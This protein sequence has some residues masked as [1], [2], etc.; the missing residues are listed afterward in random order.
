M[1]RGF[2]LPEIAVVTALAG[3]MLALA[4]PR[5][6]RAL[7]HYTADAAAR[8]IT[9]LIAT[10]RYTAIAQ[11]KRTRLR[12]NSD[13]L[14]I[15]TLG[16]VDWGLIRAW[17]GPGQRGVT[18]AASNHVVTFAPNGIPWGVANTTISLWR[19]SHVETVVVSRLGRVRRG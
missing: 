3:F 4:L 8:E 17:P 14:V 13:S 19:G 18:L 6:G 9:T 5:F 16:R 7:D 1:A 12:V 15:D 2:T 10:A 11:G